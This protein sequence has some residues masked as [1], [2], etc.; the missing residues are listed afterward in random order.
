MTLPD[1]NTS[2]QSILSICSDHN[3]SYW[4]EGWRIF[5][6]RYKLFIYKVVAKRCHAWNVNRLDIQLNMT[7]NDIVQEVLLLLCQNDGKILL[8]FRGADDEQQFRAWLAIISTRKT[9][10]YLQRYFSSRMEEDDSNLFQYLSKSLDDNHRWELYEMIVAELRDSAKNKTD[11]LERN[12][13][14]FL[15]YTLGRFFC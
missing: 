8:N 12:I 4:K 13:N 15:L 1:E 3:S 2:L 10:H 14:I 9:S 7:I 6:K 5:L 11:H